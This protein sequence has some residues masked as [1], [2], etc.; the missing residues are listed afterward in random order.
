[1]A[2]KLT[3]SEGGALKPELQ[4]YA[5]RLRALDQDGNG[6]LDMEEVCKALDE[7]AT[8]EKEKK[9]LKWAA[10]IAGLFCLLTVAATV[11]LTYAVVKLSQDINVEVR[12]RGD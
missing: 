5:T 6:E 11:G 4:R 2:L 10:G 12:R 7:M 9:V 3:A 8:M 1:M